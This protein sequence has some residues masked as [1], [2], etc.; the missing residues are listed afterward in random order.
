MSRLLLL[1]LTAFVAAAANEAMEP[2]IYRLQCM[3]GPGK[4]K[5]MALRSSNRGVLTEVAQTSGVVS[6]L[7]GSVAGAVFLGSSVTIGAAAAIAGIAVTSTVTCGGVAAAVVV[8]IPI[9]KMLKS[10]VMVLSQTQKLQ[11]DLQPSDEAP[12]GFTLKTRV[13][14]CHDHGN[15]FFI[16]KRKTG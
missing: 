10:D 12:N 4:R 2:G 3:E 13:S 14:R 8:E 1:L 6:V 7:G 5:Y 11:F 16:Q 15:N 9:L